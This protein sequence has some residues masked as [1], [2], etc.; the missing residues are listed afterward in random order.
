MLTKVDIITAQGNVLELPLGDLTDGYLV[1]EIEGLDPVK[2]T[3]VSSSF[4][5]VDGEQ[6]HSARREARNIVAHLELEPSYTTGTGKALRSNLY[7]Y[8]MPKTLV[9]LRFYDDEMPTPVDIQARVESL[10]CPPFAQVLEATISFMC[11]DPDFINPTPIVVEGLTTASEAELVINYDGTVETGILFNMTVDNAVTEFA[12]NHRAPDGITRSLV[13]EKPLSAGNT[14]DIST[15]TGAK[16]ATLTDDAN[17]SNPILYGI[18]PTSNW[19][20]LFP[21]TNYIKVFIEGY[22]FAPIPYTIEYTTR[23]G[24]L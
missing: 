14:L 4:A 9:T 10:N 22:T 3:L 12:I 16:G 7:K 11:Y 24:G 18:D 21:G 1:K 13:F 15:V 19:I 5:N 17:G 8:A 6:Y 2:A 23:Y 20:N